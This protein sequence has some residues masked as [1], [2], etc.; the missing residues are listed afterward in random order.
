MVSSEE[1]KSIYINAQYIQSLK[2]LSYQ[3][4][5]VYIKKFPCL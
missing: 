1:K 3:P 2:T 4:T 5:L